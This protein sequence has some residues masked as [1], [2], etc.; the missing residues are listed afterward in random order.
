MGDFIVT[1]SGVKFHPLDPRPEDILIEDIAH[2]LANQCRYTGHTSRY[3][4]VAEHSVRVALLLPRELRLAGL[5][6][7]AAE[8]YLGDVARPLKHS[9][10]MTPYRCA[11]RRLEAAIASRF[12]LDLVPLIEPDGLISLQVPVAVKNADA[13][14]L[15]RETLALMP[16]LGCW[17][18]WKSY[19]DLFPVP[20]ILPWG[21]SPDAAEA[22]FLQH[23]Q[24][25]TS[26]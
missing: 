20:D 3:Y 25:L 11:E 2:S 6:H 4:S 5:L 23:F 12:N 18:K 22:V 8:A 13:A 21:W 26:E 17:K 9:F 14:M 16:K 1:R 7:D 10:E 15:W 19:S 24:E